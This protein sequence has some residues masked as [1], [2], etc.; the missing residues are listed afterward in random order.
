MC[1]PRVGIFGSPIV[2][3][4]QAI[5]YALRKSYVDHEFS[6]SPHAVPQDER[7]HLSVCSFLISFKWKTIFLQ[8]YIIMTRICKKLY[9][10]RTIYEFHRILTIE[11]PIEYCRAWC[12]VRMVSK[13]VQTLHPGLKWAYPPVGQIQCHSI[14]N[15][16]KWTLFKACRSGKTKMSASAHVFLYRSNGT[17]IFIQP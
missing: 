12:T 8:P 17:K 9:Q 5:E 6:C 15:E 16:R 3:L 7:V 14:M 11:K 13:S 4:Y 10:F 1:R 2:S